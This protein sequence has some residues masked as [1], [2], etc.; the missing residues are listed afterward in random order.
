MISADEGVPVTAGSTA[1]NGLPAG[2][3]PVATAAVH[4]GLTVT[5]VTRRRGVGEFTWLRCTR[6]GDPTGTVVGAA[7]KDGRFFRGGIDTVDVAIRSVGG[8]LAALEDLA[9]GAVGRGGRG[10]RSLY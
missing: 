2:A 1:L 7:W 5:T 4:L 8:V 10:R 3:R 9:D 6:P